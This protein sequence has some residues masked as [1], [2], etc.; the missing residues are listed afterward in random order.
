MATPVYGKQFIRFAETAQV[1]VTAPAVHQ[2][3]VVEVTGAT[4]PPSIAYPA[5]GGEVLGVVQQDIPAV[6]NDKATTL[7]R[8]ATVATS[9]LLLVEQTGAG[10]FNNGDLLELGADGAAAV[11]GTIFPTVN[12][13]TPVIRQTVQIGGVKM[14]LA[15]FS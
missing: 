11:G 7:V 3:R 14:V 9:G 15:S 2:F 6:D 13:T 1:D 12:G 10:D 5:A 8:L 4:E